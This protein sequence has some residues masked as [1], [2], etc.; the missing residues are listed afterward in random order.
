MIMC[1]L[2]LKRWTP[3]LLF[4]VVLRRGRIIEARFSSNYTSL[5]Q[6][7]VTSDSMQRYQG[8]FLFRCTTS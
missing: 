2:L 1:T 6:A 4:G 8:T 7:R 5:R 3:L